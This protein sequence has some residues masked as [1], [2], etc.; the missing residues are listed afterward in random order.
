MADF[1]PFAGMSQEET[2]Q[3]T[4]MLLAAIFEKLPRVDGNDR[5]MINASEVAA[6][7]TVSGNLTNITSVSALTALQNMG[8][9]LIPTDAI[10]MHTGNAGA[11]HIYDHIKVT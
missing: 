5:L 1:Q 9:R 7:V 11:M 2:A 4:L 10:P 8:V 6:A 3:T